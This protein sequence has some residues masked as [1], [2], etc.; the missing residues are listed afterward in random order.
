MRRRGFACGALLVCLATAAAT[1]RDGT[2]P[3]WL[4]LGGMFAVVVIYPTRPC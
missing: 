1:V 4:A 3:G 2:A